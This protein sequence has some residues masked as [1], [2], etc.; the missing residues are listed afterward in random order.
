VIEYRNGQV[1]EAPQSYN[2]M[3]PASV[4]DYYGSYYPSYY[5]S[6]YYGGVG[7]Y[8]YPSPIFFTNPFHCHFIHH[9][10]FVHSQPFH[11]FHT[12]GNTAFGFGHVGARGTLNTRSGFVDGGGFRTFSSPAPR[13]DSV[14]MRV[15]R[16]QDFRGQTMAPAQQVAPSPAP[17]RSAPA[18]SGGSFR[19]GSGG[20]GGGGMSGGSLRG[21]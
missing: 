6:P 8:Y 13:F 14:P 12:F 3:E 9:G 15:G 18:G 1:I 5:P 21:R 11:D 2:D 20:G 10:G 19:G 7:Y 16:S 17:T 4:P